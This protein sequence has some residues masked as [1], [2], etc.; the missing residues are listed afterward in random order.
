VSERETLRLDSPVQVLGRTA[1]AD[2]EIEGCPVGAGQ[3][4]GSME[5]DRKL[6]VDGIVFGEGPRWH[7]GRLFFSDIG[8]HRVRAAGLDG[9]LETVLELR[10]EPSGIG[11]LPDGR[12]LVVSMQDHRLLRVDPGGLREVADLSPWCGGRANDMVVDARSRAYVGNIGFDLEAQP[13]VPRPTNLVR[14]DPDGSV[15]VAARE[16]WCPNGLAILADGRTLVAAESAAGRLAA[17]D[18]AGDGSLSSP[19]VFAK[20]PEG[21][22]PDGICADAEG[23]V[24]VASPT[25]REFLRVRSG[26]EVAERIS[27]GERIAIA[28]ALGG[29]GRGTL[30]LITSSTMSLAEAARGRTGRI[31]TCEVAVPGAGWP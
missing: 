1:L 31:E 14:V 29:A 5:R 7:A 25:T 26:G 3:P 12:M 6:L 23:A 15:H 10:G 9:R 11:W 18:V 28:C 19:R 22:A 27:T 21:V 17:F 2:T 4:G 20:L 16:L 24:W 13:I 30:F 8:D